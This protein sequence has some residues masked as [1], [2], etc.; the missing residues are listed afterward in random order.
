LYAE[1]SESIRIRCIL[2]FAMAKIKT[3]T[4]ECGIDTPK[5]SSS[6]NPMIWVS[7]FVDF[8]GFYTEY[9]SKSFICFA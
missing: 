9:T 1:L 2:W 7:H 5:K 3:K 4:S 6:E 8:R